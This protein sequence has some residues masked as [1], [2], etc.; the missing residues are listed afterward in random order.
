LIGATLV[1]VRATIT[2]NRARTAGYRVLGG[3]AGQAAAIVIVVGVLTRARERGTREQ[4][5]T[6]CQ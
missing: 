1:L 4:C 2:K 3:A 5:N 6:Q